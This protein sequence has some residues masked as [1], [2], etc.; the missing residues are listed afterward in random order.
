MTGFGPVNF[1]SDIGASADV[2]G[3]EYRQAYANAVWSLRDKVIQQF[4]DSGAT[5]KDIREVFDADTHHHV[6]YSCGGILM[7]W[8]ESIMLGRIEMAYIP[9][10]LP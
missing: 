9:E 4:L 5:R 3:E 7:R 10:R 8:T 1:C 2:Y 6:G